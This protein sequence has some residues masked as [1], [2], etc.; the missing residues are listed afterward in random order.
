MIRTEYYTT[1]LSRIIP[2][3]R[4]G[5]FYIRKVVLPKGREIRT[6]SPTGVFYF[7]KLDKDFP[8]V[9][10]REDTDIEK[11]PDQVWMSDAP[12]EQEGMRYAS[13]VAKGDIL[14]LGLGLGLLPTLIK[15]RNVGVRNRM[16]K[17]ITIVEIE[18]DVVNLVY[19]HIKTKRT[20]LIIADAKDYLEK[21]DDRYDFIFIDIWASFVATLTE[22]EH[23][24]SLASRCLKD[25]IVPEQGVRWWVQELHARIK[26]K[27]PKSPVAE[28]GKP[29][30]YPPCL[31]CG[32]TIRNDYAGLCMDCA[33]T[34]GVSEL[35]VK[36]GGQK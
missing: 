27:L 18:Q 3:G 17:S 8:T 15:M 7:D 4:S 35:F 24:A 30:V 23:W 36:K 19:D 14:V 34:L 31:V 32:K 6:Y 13:L 2:E 1:V 16:V 10:L 29:A 26:D 5:K 11:L 33:D 12:M 25:G 22:A 20:K 9:V 28:P 21:T